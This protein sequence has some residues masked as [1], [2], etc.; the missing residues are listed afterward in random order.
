MVRGGTAR[1]GAARDGAAQP[2]R[3]A[4]RAA[5]RRAAHACMLFQFSSPPL[6]FLGFSLSLLAPIYPRFDSFQNWPCHSFESPLNRRK[7][8][9][10][11]SRFVKKRHL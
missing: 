2:R 8:R 7:L 4:R 10:K 6:S 11:K 5:P 9:A 1:S 3:T